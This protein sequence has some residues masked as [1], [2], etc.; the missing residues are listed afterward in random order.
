N[1]LETG[2][3]MPSKGAVPVA[4]LFGALEAD[5]F[6]LVSQKGLEWRLVQSRLCVHSD[7]RMLEIMLRNL[8]TNALRYTE[9][10][11]ILLGCRRTGDNVRIEVWDSGVGIAEEHLPRIFD[12]YYQVADHTHLGSFGLGLAIVQRLGNLLSHRVDVRSTSGEG[13]C[14]SIEVPL[15]REGA[16]AGNGKALPERSPTPALRGTILVIEDDSFVRSGIEMLL[17]SEGMNVVSAA[18]GQE[19]LDVITKKGVRPDV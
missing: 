18:N 13:S 10:G 16:S 14:F 7:R 2:V 19:A 12:E 4:D 5:L 8:L 1:R 11:R 3:L 17:A 15:A 6:E 9:R